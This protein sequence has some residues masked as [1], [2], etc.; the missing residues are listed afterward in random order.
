MTVEELEAEVVRLRT[1]IATREAEDGAITRRIVEV[2][3]HHRALRDELDVVLNDVRALQKSVK[4]LL[5]K[6]R[7]ELG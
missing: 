4:W 5:G 2:N 3:D 6:A 7:G 1:L